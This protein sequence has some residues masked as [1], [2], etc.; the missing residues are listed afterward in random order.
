MFGCCC[1]LRGALATIRPALYSYWCMPHYLVFV[2]VSSSALLTVVLQYNRVLL[3]C[4]IVLCRVYTRYVARIQVLSTCI[5]LY[6]LTPTTRIL[7]RRQNCLLRG[8]TAT[9]YPLVSGDIVS[10]CI[11]IHRARPGYLYPATCVWCRR[12]SSNDIVCAASVC[13]FKRRLNS[14]DFSF[15]KFLYVI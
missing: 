12:G 5:H 1:S 2:V 13:A 14:F 9:L 10:T 11:R 3:L 7:Y 8:I 6:R 15:S 4:G